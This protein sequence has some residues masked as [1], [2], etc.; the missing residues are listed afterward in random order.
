MLQADVLCRRTIRRR[1]RAGDPPHS[2]VANLD[3]GGIPRVLPA[4]R[5][6]TPVIMRDPLKTLQRNPSALVHIPNPAVVRT[7]PSALSATLT[8]PPPP[9]IPLSCHSRRPLF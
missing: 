3:P 2:S 1:C 8:S 4:P 5:C 9:M 7:V 6:F